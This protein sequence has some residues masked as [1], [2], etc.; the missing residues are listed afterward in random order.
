M[1]LDV[2]SNQPSVGLKDS[3]GLQMEE[4]SC[5]TKHTRVL[6]LP[7]A[8]SKLTQQAFF[9]LKRDPAPAAG[10]AK[11]YHESQ[12]RIFKTDAPMFVGAG[13]GT[14]NLDF[15]ADLSALKVIDPDEVNQAIPPGDQPVRRAIRI[16]LSS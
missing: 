9:C 5:A 1:C 14:D 15:L 6:L 2:D 7:P 13:E 8:L 4:D 12:A 10:A 16:F 11:A 3:L